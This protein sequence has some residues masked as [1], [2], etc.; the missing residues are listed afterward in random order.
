LQCG[1]WGGRPARVE[2]NC[3]EAR[4]SLAGEGLEEGLGVTRVWFGGSNGGRATPV[5]GHAD[6]QGGVAAAAA[7]RGEP[8]AGKGNGRLGCFWRASEGVLLCDEGVCDPYRRSARLCSLPA[9]TVPAGTA[10][11]HAVPRAR[12]PATR[13]AGPRDARPWA[14]G[15]RMA[16]QARAAGTGC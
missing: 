14:Q 12:L 3:V 15:H 8:P 2:H 9:P 16:R 4:R 7:Q 1:P 10:S 13:G 6:G 5:S 11:W